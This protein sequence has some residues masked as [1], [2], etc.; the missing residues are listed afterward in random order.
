MKTFK[1]EVSLPL[2][3]EVTKKELS[4]VYLV[5]HAC[6]LDYRFNEWFKNKFLKYGGK[7]DDDDMRA[8]NESLTKFYNSFR[9]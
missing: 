8:L 3:L 7:T 6:N 5:C 9:V 1:I 4:S 2:H